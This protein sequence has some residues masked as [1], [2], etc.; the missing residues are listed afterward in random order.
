MDS[1]R[2]WRFA[3]TSDVD[4]ARKEVG[5]KFYDVIFITGSND[6]I[7]TIYCS[8]DKL[9]LVLMLNFSSINKFTDPNY[10]VIYMKGS[11]PSQ[12]VRQLGFDAVIE[13]I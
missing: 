8:H 12:V 10:L 1:L 13:K 9:N 7:L 11:D 5:L 3:Q 4:K 6:G 2:E